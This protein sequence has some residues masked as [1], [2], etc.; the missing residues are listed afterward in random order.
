MVL[1]RG[2]SVELRGTGAQG[3]L[4]ARLTQGKKKVAE[5]PVTVDGASWS[6]S[7]PPLT[8]KQAK[9]GPL[10]LT[11]GDYT[12]GD[13]LVGD[14]VFCS[15]Q[16]NMEL[17]VVRVMDKYA[18]ELVGASNDQVRLLMVQRACGYDGPLADIKTD[19]WK[20]LSE[21]TARGFSALGYFLG[22]QLQAERGV[23]VG[24]VEAAVGGTPIEAWLTANDLREGG[25]REALAE[26]RINANEQYRQAVDEYANKVG[27]TWDVT[28]SELLSE[29]VDDPA[30]WR[31]TDYD[32]S[33]W[34]QGDLVKGEWG[35]P[36]VL[37]GVHYLRQT[38][39]LPAQ[40]KGRE[41][42]LRL[43]TLV[44]ADIT[45]VNGKKVGETTYQYPPRI[46][47]IPSGVLREGTNVVAVRLTAQGWRP[48]VVADKWRGL[49]LG[50]DPWLCSTHEAAVELSPVWRH[51]FA[52]AMPARKG[53][54]TWIY[55]PTVMHNGMVAP[56]A[57][58]RVSG[59]VWYQGESNCGRSQLYADQ[60]RRLLKL[61]RKHFA[62]DRLP[63]VVVELADFE[64]PVGEGWRAV[65][66]AQADVCDDDPN[67][68][69]AKAA[70]LGEWNDIHPLAKKEVAQR[71]AQ[72][73][74]KLANNP[75]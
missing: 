65:Q 60:L 56:L 43:G 6:C 15:G 46:Y 21:A 27:A 12:A 13:I 58:M 51:R 39:D 55:T 73:L 4:V 38:I 14:V 70:D 67:A 32:D 45:Y 10:T 75:K 19:G 69:L 33:Q 41:A 42:T 53:G 24:V 5:A 25:Y 8:D 36:G 54:E 52:A 18:A 74:N 30:A 37:R 63:V 26:L 66:K 17:P 23:P 9:G 40:W 34:P 57:G 49:Y 62:S 20:H 31:A 47:H 35:D 28:A 1:Q 2:Q 64:R 22:L 7:L 16:S 61:Y 11:I 29:G 71:V 72:Q 3:P 50:G 44:D 59:C 68:A 48:N